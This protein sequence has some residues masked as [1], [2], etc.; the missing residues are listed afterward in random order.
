MK[1]KKIACGTILL[2]F[3]I[4]GL[5]SV[6]DVSADSHNL[7]PRGYVGY[8]EYCN[9][10]DTIDYEITS[11]RNINIYIM[12]DEQL[13]LYLAGSELAPEY[14]LVQILSVSYIHY[15][16]FI[17]GNDGNYC[18][19]ITN[20]S[21]T[22]EANIVV[23]IRTIPGEPEK[24]IIILSPKATDTF[25]IGSNYITWTSTGDIDHVK[26]ELYKDGY[27]LETIVS[28]TDNDG[29]YTW[30]LGSNDVYSEGQFY[31]IIIFDYYDDSIYDCSDYFKIDITPVDYYESD[32]FLERLL[33]WS[34][35]IFVPIGIVIIVAVV[36]IKKHKRKA[37]KE[38][39]VIQEREVTK[40]IYCSECG[41]EILDKGRMFCSK[42]GTKIIK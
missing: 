27:F 11:D 3:A 1:N 5:C 34:L 31:Q 40:N 4:S 14:F 26:I 12:N 2:L 33:W 16:Y 22:N 19:L 23:L 32:Y 24:S 37:P 7:S 20:P 18:V 13:E 35:I 25:D 39:I 41:A 15:T 10:G 28:Y 21:Y 36:L 30:Y 6:I 17:D 38:V 8:S 9:Y 29:S 42:C